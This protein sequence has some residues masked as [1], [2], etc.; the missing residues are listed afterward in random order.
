[1]RLL[2][3]R[4]TDGNSG[5]PLAFDFQSLNDIHFGRTI[6]IP[7]HAADGANAPRSKMSIPISS[8][9]TTL[10]FSFF[11]PTFLIHSRLK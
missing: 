5:R 11:D 8:P 6:A 3:M 1:M 4:G 10:R 2:N 7:Y 9:M